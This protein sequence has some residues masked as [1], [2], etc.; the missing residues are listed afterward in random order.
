MG[1][2]SVTVLVDSGGT[3]NFI[4]EQ[5]EKR[6]GL[7]AQ[8]AGQLKVMVVLGERLG[9]SDKYKNIELTLQGVPMIVDFYLL[10]LEGYNVV[11][12]T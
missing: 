10:P 11:L 2:K 4:F 3:H 12:G 8:S 5:M 9:S 6:A 1:H 7:Q